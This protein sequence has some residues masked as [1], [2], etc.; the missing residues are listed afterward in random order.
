M[1]HFRLAHSFPD[2]IVNDLIEQLKIYMDLVGKKSLCSKNTI[3]QG[4]DTPRNARSKNDI[5]PPEDF[6]NQSGLVA[7]SA[8]FRR[9]SMYSRVSSVQWSRWQV[10]M[11]RAAA[12]CNMPGLCRI[13]RNSGLPYKETSVTKHP[14]HFEN[15]TACATLPL[16][17]VAGSAPHRRSAGGAFPSTSERQKHLKRWQQIPLGT[18]AHEHQTRSAYQAQRIRP[19]LVAYSPD[20]QPRRCQGQTLIEQAAHNHQSSCAKPLP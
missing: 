13:S 7:R 8:H 19:H 5:F 16:P 18:H 1:R 3:H 11:T 12:V 20:A 15:W 2:W 14:V 4:I 9:C 6:Q 10:A 17:A